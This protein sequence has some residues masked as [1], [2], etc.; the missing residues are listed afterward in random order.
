MRYISETVM[1]GSL[2]L[3]PVQTDLP[4][5]VFRQMSTMRRSSLSPGAFLEEVTVR[6][7]PQPSSISTSFPD[8]PM[9]DRDLRE[10]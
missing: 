4:S 8:D 3:M 5:D 10:G 6:G 7:R 9:A 1:E 2:R